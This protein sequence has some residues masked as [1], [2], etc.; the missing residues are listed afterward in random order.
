MGQYANQPDFATKAKALIPNNTLDE[1]TFLNGAAVYVGGTGDINV[2]MTGTPPRE[3]V[4]EFSSPGFSGSNG[5]GYTTLNGVNTYGGSVGSGGLTV[6][7][8]ADPITQAITSI[9]VAAAGTGYKNG[10]LIYVEKGGVQ[11]DGVFRIITKLQPI[12]NGPG[13][14]NQP[15]VFKN[16]QEGS[17][18]PVIVDYVLS[19]KTTATSLVAVY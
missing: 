17:F 18:V 7:I 15:V 3:T 9:S 8:V 6:D 4:I 13:D 10:D 1:S 14:I 2:V 11:G 16:I 5:T 12:N 19:T